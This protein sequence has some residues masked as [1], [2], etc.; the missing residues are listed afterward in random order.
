[1]CRSVKKM[2]SIF[3]FAV[4]ILTTASALDNGLALTPPMGWL[5]WER[6]RCIVDCVAYPDDCVR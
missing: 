2:L 4:S 1:M 6:Y 3:V 5:A